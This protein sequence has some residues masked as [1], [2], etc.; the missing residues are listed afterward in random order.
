MRRRD[1]DD[2]VELDL[3]VDLPPAR[4]HLVSTRS[5]RLIARVQA[6]AGLKD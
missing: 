1:N 3:G 4:Y 2:L 5:G 6:V